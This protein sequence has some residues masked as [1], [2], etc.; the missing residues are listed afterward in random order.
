MFQINR[1]KLKL[2]KE[3]EEIVIRQTRFERKTSEQVGALVQTVKRM[4]ADESD[5]DVNDPE[6]R[7]ALDTIFNHATTPGCG[8]LGEEGG[9]GVQQAIYLTANDQ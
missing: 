6:E 3:L 9:G 1:R 5:L 2:N 4:I 8:Y 7:K